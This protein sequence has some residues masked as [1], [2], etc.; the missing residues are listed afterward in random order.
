MTAICEAG[1]KTV[2]SG[3]A[4]RPALSLGAKGPTRMSP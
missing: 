1:V 2:T 3:S 4:G